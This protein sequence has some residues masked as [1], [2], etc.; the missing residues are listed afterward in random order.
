MTRLHII[1]SNE[2]EQVM[3][4]R[5]YLRQNG[6]SKKLAVRVQHN[7]QHALQERRRF[8]PE[9]SVE[10]LGIVSEPLRVELHFEIYSGVLAAHP[11]FARYIEEC[12]QIMCR[13]CHCAMS[14]L[15]V[16]HGDTIFTAGETPQYPKTYIVCS[17][18]LQYVSLTGN[19]ARVVEE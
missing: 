6:V 18:T 10:L 5:R 3:V 2:S 4:L 15:L 16:S 11:F 17:G 19:V 12:P 14:E 9:G 1:S 8:M 13:V 7:A